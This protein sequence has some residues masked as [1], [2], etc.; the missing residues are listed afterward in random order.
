MYRTSPEHCEEDS[1]SE[2][3]S[4]RFE[5]LTIQSL[6]AAPEMVVRVRQLM[7]SDDENVARGACGLM[8]QL[9]RDAKEL[10]V[11]ARLKLIEE[12]M[13]NTQ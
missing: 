11:E 4:L 1:E 7:K 3:R 12:R 13:E 6:N 9:L 8:R 2:I 5:H 10:D